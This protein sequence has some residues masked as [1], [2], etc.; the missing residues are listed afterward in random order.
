LGIDY[1]ALIFDPNGVRNAIA[2]MNADA[3]EAEVLRNRLVHLYTG[4]DWRVSLNINPKQ[5]EWSENIDTTQPR[6]PMRTTMMIDWS[7]YV[8]VHPP[9][10]TDVKQIGLG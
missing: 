3:R 5:P 2:N 8:L 1:G 10:D 7:V 9:T 6:Y 4:L